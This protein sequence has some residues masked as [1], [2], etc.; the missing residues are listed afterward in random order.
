MKTKRFDCR[1]CG[2]SA[3][4]TPVHPVVDGWACRK[5]HPINE[6]RSTT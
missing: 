1:T 5:C 4:D 2:A 6:R 3:Y